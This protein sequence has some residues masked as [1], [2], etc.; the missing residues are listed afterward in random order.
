MNRRALLLASLLASPLV[1]LAPRTPLSG[2]SVAEAS[3]SRLLTLDELV[4]SSTY[5]VVGT[6]GERRSVWEELPSGRRI[7]TYTRVAIERAAVGSPGQEIWVRTLGGTVDKIGQAVPGEAQLTTG[8]RAM[9]FLAHVNGVV[10][11]TAMA[12]GHYP[13]IT[14]EKGVVRLA[15]SPD[16]GMLV[17]R[18]GPSIG[19]RERLVGSALEDALSLVQKTRKARDEQK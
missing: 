16:T 18:P 14:D 17:P 5:V 7:V 15:P 13:V 8:Q 4:A 19:A 9:L 12:Q 6:A 10:V 3:V 1:T 2:E 11:V